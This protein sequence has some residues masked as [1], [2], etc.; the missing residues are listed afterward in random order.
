MQTRYLYILKYILPIT[1]L[2]MLNLVYLASYHI[3]GSLGKWVSY[4]LFQQYAVICNLLWLFNALFFGL[5]TEFSARKLE[6][7]YRGTWR[8][9]IAHFVLFSLYL[10]YE[11]DADFSRTFILVFYIGLTVAF[12]LNRFLGTL[13]QFVAINKMNATKKI[14]VMGLNPTGRRLAEYFKQQRNVNFYGF[15]GSNDNGYNY[16]TGLLSDIAV[17]E[18]EAAKSE[19]VN[20]MYVAVPPE[21]MGKIHVL[22]QEADKYC[23][24]IK[25]VPDIAGSIKVPYT[26]DYIGKEFPVIKLRNEPLED[27]GNRFKK[28]AFDVIFSSLVIVFLL[29]WLF[30]IIAIII[31]IQSKG[32][33]L[34][35][36][37]RSGRNDSPFWCYKFRSMHVNA[38]SDKV[39][40]TKGDSRIFPFGQLMRKTSMDELPQFFNVLFGDMS[41]VG[42][43]PH[44]LKHTEEYKALVNQ[45]MVRHFMKPGI[46]GWAQVNGFRGETNREGAMESRVRYDIWY[47]ENWTGNLDVKIIFMTVIN[48]LRGEDNAY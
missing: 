30:P 19:G 36:Q 26:I 22:I 8:S 3:T 16:Q 1:D 11:R 25:L 20:E 24:R 10:L 27:I 47:L 2:L 34:F 9:I 42:P 43:R 29:S 39:Q 45:F 37:Q 46:T 4:P 28:R 41:V 33:I 14:A 12:A 17:A 38:G 44:M 15:I 13:I 35:K 23:L 40:A 7:I 18:M 21:R 6:R 32:P 48:V 5:Y 31:K